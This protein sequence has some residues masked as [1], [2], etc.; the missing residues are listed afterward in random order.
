MKRNPSPKQRFIK[1]YARLIYGDDAKSNALTPKDRAIVKRLFKECPLD[2]L[3]AYPAW[4]T[5]NWPAIQSDLANDRFNGD[6]SR[7]GTYLFSGGFLRVYL[8]YIM[9]GKPFP[10]SRR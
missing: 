4:I 10:Y 2:A 6:S 1:E 7:P 9:M 3:L 5:Q 8:S